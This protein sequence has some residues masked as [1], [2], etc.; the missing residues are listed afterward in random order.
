MRRAAGALHAPF[1]FL[2]ARNDHDAVRFREH[3]RRQSLVG[4]RQDLPQYC[5]G[6]A[7]PFRG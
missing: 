1:R 6:F 5:R 4:R 2:E 3:F 7:E